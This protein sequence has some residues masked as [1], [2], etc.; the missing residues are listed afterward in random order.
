L[1][2]IGVVT[3]DA[4]GFDGAADRDSSSFS[5]FASIPSAVMFRDA[6]VALTSKKWE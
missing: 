5:R 6:A 1:E 4:K 3:R 2:A